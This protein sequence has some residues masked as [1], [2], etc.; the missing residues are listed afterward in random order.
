VITLQWKPATHRT[1]GGGVV[2][3]SPSPF[4]ARRSFDSCRDRCLAM[5]WNQFR[6]LVS[7]TYLVGDVVPCQKR[8]ESDSSERGAFVMPIYIAIVSDELIFSFQLRFYAK[9]YSAERVS[10]PFLGI[11]GLTK[12]SCQIK[13]RHGTP[14]QSSRSLP[15]Q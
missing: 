11:A 13:S 12:A 6:D 9:S 4:L 7:I 3:S 5:G 8:T 15:L 1:V 2:V 10:S 14:S